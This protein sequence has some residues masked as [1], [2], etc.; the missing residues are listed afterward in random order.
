M[1][2]VARRLTFIL[3]SF[4]FAL[5]AQA[6]DEQTYRKSIDR[7]GGEIKQISRNLNANKKLLK[8]ERD[9]L[10]AV[11]QK[12]VKLKTQI[13]EVAKE[14][15]RRQ[16]EI[17]SL[18]EKIAAAREDQQNHRDVLAKLLLSRYKQGRR[19]YVQKVLNQENP[20]AVGRLANY[21]Y[22]FTEA[23]QQRYSE[24]ETLIGQSQALHTEHQKA[25]SDLVSKREEQSQL[26]SQWQTSQRERAATV[27]KL[28]RK[29][30]DSTEKLV[31]LKK[32]RARL[33]SLLTQIA[34]QAAEMRRLDAERQKQAAEQ[35]R[36]QGKQVTR[37]ER[38]AVDGGFLKQRGR[39]TF[40]VSGAVK[41][42]FGSRLPESGMRS[43]GMFFNTP[44]PKQVRSIF[45]GRVL[46]ADFLKGYG[47]LMIVD[48]GDQHISL[49]GHNE[50]LYKRV[51]DMVDTN[52]VIGKTGVTGGLKSPGLY[53]EI[54]KNADPVDPAVWC[55]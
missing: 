30:G 29:V 10:L 52:E 27:E 18:D 54:R 42:R 28:N 17:E 5:T 1:L 40:P 37:V 39:L 8:T 7:I 22:Y 26:Q 21:H 55:Q 16:A 53:F 33:N 15:T 25:L 13:N 12:L 46:F 3:V 24:L 35:A 6:N 31:Q 43:D 50:V 41:T 51:G 23:I 45:R 14:I 44:E 34:K 49:Y 11:E 48:H 20:Y 9:E 2:Y 36:Q 32:D 47:L 4:G 19:D 38:P